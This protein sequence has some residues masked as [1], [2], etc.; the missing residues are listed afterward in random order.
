MLIAPALLLGACSLVCAQTDSNQETESLQ[1]KSDLLANQ[2]FELI[3]QEKYTEARQILEELKKTDPEDVRIPPLGDLISQ[4]EREADPAKKQQLVVQFNETMLRKLMEG[5]QTTTQ[6]LETLN[7]KLDELGPQT[8]GQELCLAAAKGDLQ[9]VSQFLKEGVSADAK[10]QFGTTA[11]E[12]A[13]GK[14]YTDVVKLLLSRGANVHAKGM[15]GFTPLMTPARKGDVDTVRILIDA[16][17]DVNAKSDTGV[18]ALSLA[19]QS[20]HSRVI[21][22]L[23]QAGAKE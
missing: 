19:K 14:G 7:T 23:I 3:K 5:L 21:E 11:L 8:L 22:L 16:G 13:S 2:V 1:E 4:L 6:D 18:T 20:G 9:T 10:D 17:I 15:L 12:H